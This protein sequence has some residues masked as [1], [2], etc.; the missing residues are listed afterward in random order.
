M[1]TRVSSKEP[2]SREEFSGNETWLICWRVERERGINE[3]HVMENITS[4][5]S[6]VGLRRVKAPV[7][8]DLE[9]GHYYYR[10]VVGRDTTPGLIHSIRRASVRTGAVRDNL[11]FLVISAQSLSGVHSLILLLYALYF[12]DVCDFITLLKVEMCDGF[13]KCPRY[14]E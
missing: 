3:M 1:R 8:L 5:F 10:L 4:C 13:T 14:V 6:R 12:L 11:P 2:G 7:Q 9:R